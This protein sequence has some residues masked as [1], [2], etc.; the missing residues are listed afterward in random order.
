MAAAVCSA[1]AQ[2]PLPS[3]SDRWVQVRTANFTLYGNASESKTKE[4][5]LE[6][7]R[8]RAVL[9]L[10]KRGSAANAPVPT[11]V[12]V[13]KS[14]SAL[15]V[16]LPSEEDGKLV[17]WNSVYQGGWDGN[18]A[19]LSAGWN[20][21]PRP[22]VYHSYIYDFIN[23][24]FAE[25]P[26]WYEVG[27]AGYYSTFQTEGDEARTGMIPQRSLHLLRE[28]GMW[29]PL[30]RLLAVQRDSPEYRDPDRMSLYYAESWA[31]VHYLMQGNPERA[32]QLGRYLSLRAQG[33][34]Q[35]EAFREAFGT[36]YAKLYGELTSYVQNNKRF[37]YNRFKF[38]ELKTPNETRTTPMTYDDVVVRL[39]DL[40]AHTGR[41]AD[42]ERYYEA[43]LAAN[44][45]NAEAFA[46]LAWVRRRQER[47]EEA[48]ALARQ[49][50]EAGS[51]D[52]RAYYADGRG[53]WEALTEKPQNPENLDPKFR[54]ELEAARASFRR[55]LELNPDFAE[56]RAALGRTYR[57]EPRGAT[58][59][60]GIAALEAARRQLPKR[61]DV[62]AD[63]AA[64]YDRKGDK[65]R[66]DA[67]L[68]PMTGPRAAAAISGRNAANDFEA[69]AAEIHSL[70][71][72]ARFD[73]A[74]AKLDALMQEAEGDTRAQMETYRKDLSRTAALKR[75]VA[76][77]DAALALYN[78]RKLDAA[79]TA[80]RKLAAE[81]PDSD[82]A[83]AARQKA[84]EI[85]R[86]LSK[87]AG[88][89]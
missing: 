49:A 53:R 87:K 51:T 69:R 30:E 25:L 63:L 56:A 9:L 29:L 22:T 81:S 44:R 65:A 42:G 14:Q 32:P 41:L 75:A 72:A 40:L 89:P 24:N 16:Y 68:A 47:K 74:L 48:A 55:S 59:D 15:D 38:T 82:V 18:Y 84:T 35:D 57:L 17:R 36:T 13:F 23:A 77:Y 58:I 1:P 7:E 52:F 66:G 54:A 6:M 85:E 60:E 62:A 76:D 5:G 2:L 67:L 78:Q 19:M 71:A 86:I 27:I 26:L 31:L 4:V 73:E 88:K 46:G 3:K 45:A 70:V 8:L 11:W 37:T 79:L 39:G 64:L 50:V 34:P 83:A 33:R 10:L 61:E 43:A 21:D 12:Y 80:F 28:Q 20:T